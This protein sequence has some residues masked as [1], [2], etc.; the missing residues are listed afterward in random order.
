V[1]PGDRTAADREP[2]DLDHNATTPVDPRVLE[3]FVAVERAC[4]GNPGSPHSAG[5]RARAALEDARSQAAAALGVAADEVVFV[6]SCSEANNLAVRGLGALD[7]PVL[8]ADEVE[9]KSVRE[10]AR[11]RGLVRWAVDRSGRAQVAPPAQPVGLICL[12]HGQGEVGSLQPVAAAAAL[13]AEL[14]VPLHVDAAQT[15]G[16]LPLGEV[17][18][19]AASVA[20]SAHK[21]GGLRGASAW[22]VRGPRPEP[23]LVGGGQ[24]GGLR[25]GTPSP[26]LAAATALAIELAIAETG[27]RAAAMRAA[28]EA[29]VQTLSAAIT[30]TLLTPEEG[31]PNT[32]T[33]HFDSIE[34]RAL[35][36]ALDLH[37]VRAS[38][39][40]ACASGTPEP[41]E[42]MVA[43]G[44]SPADAGRC[45]RFA[46]SW[47]T[48][49]ESAREAA[50]RVAAVVE[51]LRGQVRS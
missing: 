10:P 51:R 19:S 6:A 32:A 35:L 48:S 15:L 29:F 46:T 40:S 45:V 50:R 27:P 9:H 38:Q 44:W 24:E 43:M 30:C 49:I 26:A 47:R 31:L 18:G 2:V 25:P 1:R 20:V 33:F 39:G 28:R 8:L 5:R 14:G 36:P 23:L 16:R 21:I 41:P 11:R 17:L 13:A 3:R 42:V 12:C 7:R 4:P 22:V 34:G 37:G